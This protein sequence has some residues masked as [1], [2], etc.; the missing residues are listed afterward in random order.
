MKEQV[1]HH[2]IKVAQ[3][4]TVSIQDPMRSL[5]LSS[6]QPQIQDM[7]KLAASGES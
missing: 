2:S 5:E 1:K 6:D 3:D 4:G 7:N